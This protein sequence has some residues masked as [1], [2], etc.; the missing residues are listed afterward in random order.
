M[1]VIFHSKYCLVFASLKKTKKGDP[2]T[3]YDPFQG[4]IYL[5]RVLLYLTAAVP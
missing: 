3:I 1:G 4:S 2:K 5:A